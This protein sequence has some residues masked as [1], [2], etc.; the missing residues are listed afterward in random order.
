MFPGIAYILALRRY[1]TTA[2]RQKWSTC[3]FHSLAW[4]FLV[5]YVAILASF[6]YV[7]FLKLTGRL[8][9]EL[10]VAVELEV[11]AVEIVEDVV[12]LP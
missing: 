11:S 4:F 12:E 9:E 8:P 5:L 6:F 1:G 10:D 7:Q 3:G 2:H